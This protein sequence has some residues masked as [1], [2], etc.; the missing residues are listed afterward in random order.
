[1]SHNVIAS[2]RQQGVSLIEALVALAVMA[3]GMIGLVGVQSTLRSNSD[4]AKQRSEAVR[5]AQEA[6]EEWRSFAVLETHPT[7]LDY[8]DIVVG[9]TVDPDIA[10]FNATY[11]RTRSVA[12]L[13]T[14]QRGKTL[15]VK[16]DW[17][18]RT[19]R[20][21]QISMST[22]LTEVAPELGATLAVPANG[23]PV[24]QPLNRNRGIPVQA[25]DL[26]DGRSGLIPPSAPTGVAW[27]FNNVSGLITLCTTTAASTPSLSTAN[28]T[29]GSNNAVLVAGFVRYSFRSTPPTDA[30]ALN[31]AS[32]PPSSP[33]PQLQ[34]HVRQT[35]PLVQDVECYTSDVISPAAYTAYFC[36]VPVV[37]VPNNPPPTWSGR[38][39]F[40]PLDKVAA[41]AAENANTQWKM[42][43][44]FSVGSYND[45]ADAL[46]NQNYLAI[47]AGD[48]TASFSCPTA[49]PLAPTWP[50]QPAS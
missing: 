26:G 10:Q 46:L 18:D 37:V 36:A 16:V 6:V 11:T 25:R 34:V 4:V 48:G 39:E 40:L 47:L 29:C 15:S 12:L 41:T 8:T 44:Y 5:L 42:C 17:T 32:L 1:M 43:R 45:M 35:A 50:H 33:E 3:F 13:E 7:A 23:T 49:G 30:D 22:V 20:A 2:R 21:Q 38:L 27:V 9:D 24:R 19:G 31:P 28:V 14:P